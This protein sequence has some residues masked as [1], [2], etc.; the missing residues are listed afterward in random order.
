MSWL[1]MPI[2]P[3]CKV[4]LTT[5]RSDTTYKVLGARG[6]NTTVTLPLMSDVTMRSK[7]V[8]EHL[9][10]HCKALDEC[11]LQRIVSSKLSDR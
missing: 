4:V 2:P 10:M 5:V 3:H 9:A 6:D 7:V 8:R 11:Q 1:P